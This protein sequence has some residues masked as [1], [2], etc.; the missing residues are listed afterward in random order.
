MCCILVRNYL[1]FCKESLWYSAFQLFQR[2][3][4]LV[5]P[6]CARRI[7]EN[8]FGNYDFQSGTFERPN[9]VSPDKTLRIALAWCYLHNYLQEMKPHVYIDCG[10]VNIENRET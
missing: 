4:C 5:L 10:S 8:A 6:S 3:E 9:C 1:N 2:N 7:V